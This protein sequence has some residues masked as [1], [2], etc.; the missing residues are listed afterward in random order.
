[1]VGKWNINF[2]D[3]LEKSKDLNDCSKL[4]DKQPP[5]VGFRPD[6][7]P[8]SYEVSPPSN[9][10]DSSSSPSDDFAKNEQI[11]NDKNYVTGTRFDNGKARNFICW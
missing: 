3:D 8:M 2:N 7:F 5:V 1:M 10:S 4:K 6:F 9:S 11:H